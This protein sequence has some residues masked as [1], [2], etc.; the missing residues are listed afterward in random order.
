[1]DRPDFEND[2]RAVLM[3]F[4]P[5]EKILTPVQLARLKREQKELRQ[6]LSAVFSM[7]YRENAVLC[8]RI[9]QEEAM[10]QVQG[11]TKGALRDKIKDEM[12]TLLS[13]HTGRTLPWGTLTGV[14]PTKIPMEQMEQGRSAQQAAAWMESKYRVSAEKAWLAAAV[15]ERE[16]SLIRPLYAAGGN[17]YDPELPCPGYSL[18]LGIPF[19]PSVC[20]YCSFSSFPVKEWEDRIGEYLLALEDEME[21]TAR[22]LQETGRGRTPLTFYMGGGTPTS[23]SPQQLDR[24]LCG[25]EKHFDLSSCLEKTVEAGRPDSITRQKLQVLRRHGIDRISINPQTMHQKTLDIIGRRHSVED[26][27]Q[28]FALAR[29]EGF[30]NINMDIIAGL[31]G[32]G[33]EEMEETMEQICMLK[34]DSITVHSLAL[35]RAADMN[36]NR[37]SYSFSGYENASGMV[38][39]SHLRAQQAGLMPYYLYRQKNIAGNL[40]NVGFARPGAEC[41]YNIIIME[42]IQDILALGSGSISKRIYPGHRIDRCANVKSVNDYISRTKEMAERKRVLFIR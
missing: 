40:E 1:M 36:L 42:E 37:D 20:A 23:L 18:Y 8:L 10:L 31:P 28:A 41:I 27:V 13:T 3:S 21:K 35:K 26:I 25:L 2:I 19:C 5:G 7:Q 11:L 16:L 29:E 32:E 14:R 4:Y 9:D 17:R 39:I 15:A 22:L 12:Y 33:P 30:S 6:Q 38:R 34:P 24:V